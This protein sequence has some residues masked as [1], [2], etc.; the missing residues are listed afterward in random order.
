VGT[1]PQAPKK[2]RPAGALQKIKLGILT[3]LVPIASSCIFN[4]VLINIF[5]A[6]SVF[7]RVHPRPV[8]SFVF[9]SLA[10]IES[11]FICVHLCP[12]KFFLVAALPP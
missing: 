1:H 3:D 6:S 10:N 7:I 12:D 2:R 4:Y 9:K 11:V 8:K 5:N